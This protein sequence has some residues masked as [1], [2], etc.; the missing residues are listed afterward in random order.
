MSNQ[1]KEQPEFPAGE[2][3][4][5]YWKPQP[6]QIFFCGKTK[7]KTDFFFFLFDVFYSSEKDV[8]FGMTKES[9]PVFTGLTYLL[10]SQVKV[11]SHV[12]MSFC[13]K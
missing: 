3:E 1:S 2:V 10:V 11:N 5:G 6:R 8:T 13:C 4:T 7:T 12:F 9:K